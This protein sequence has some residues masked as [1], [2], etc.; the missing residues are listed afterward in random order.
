MSFA[1]PVLV[2][3]GVELVWTGYDAFSPAS[4]LSL[5]ISDQDSSQTT[6]SSLLAT[7]K[8]INISSAIYMADSLWLSC[9]MR[10]LHV[11]LPLC[12]VHQQTLS[13]S[14]SPPHPLSGPSSTSSLK[15]GDTIHQLATSAEFKS[16]R[17]RVH[18]QHQSSQSHYQQHQ[19]MKPH[20][21]RAFFSGE[22]T[23]PRYLSRRIMLSLKNDMEN[24]HPL[25]I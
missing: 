1:P 6:K 4:S 15:S 11:W 10:G 19:I 18:S 3:S 7:R 9:G 14:Y 13:Q 20:Q 17:R 12:H 2:A 25:G 16:S 21:K 23:T 5:S 24:A 8:S 22:S